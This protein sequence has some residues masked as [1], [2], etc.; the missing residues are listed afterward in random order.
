MED[1]QDRIVQQENVG[2]YFVSTV[3]LPYDMIEYLG[4]SYETMIKLDDEW[5]DYQVRCDTIEEANA[6][7]NNAKQWVMAQFN[8]ENHGVLH[9]M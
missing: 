6:Q 8:S 2:N 4:Y 3:R 7:H 5:T 1:I 9:E